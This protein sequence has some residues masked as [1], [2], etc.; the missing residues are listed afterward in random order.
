MLTNIGQTRQRIRALLDRAD[1]PWLSDAEIDEFVESALSEFVRERATVA[2][3][4][5]EGRDDLGHFV[6]RETFYLFDDVQFSTNVNAT[7]S[8]ENPGPLLNIITSTD[9]ETGV[10]DLFNPLGNPFTDTFASAINIGTPLNANFN[11]IN[12]SPPLR[13]GTVLS[14]IVSSN[15]AQP[16][17]CKLLSH[18][19]ASS[20]RRDPFNAPD[21]FNYTAT[22]VGDFY[23]ISPPIEN[24]LFVTNEDDTQTFEIKKVTITYISNDTFATQIDQLPTHSIEEVALIAV[25]KILGSTGDD[26]INAGTAEVQQIKGK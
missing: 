8:I 11:Q 14:I 9:P 15:M 16:V 24:S 17:N 13:V 25:R 21:T 5:Q 4:T 6:K 7:A 22:R 10:A 23:T 18:D 3:S 12:F 19:K 20:V 26:R 2:E 1:S